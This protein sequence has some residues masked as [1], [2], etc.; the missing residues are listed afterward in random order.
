LRD[1][2]A[3]D[4]AALVAL[5][6]AAYRVEAEIVRGQRIDDAGV[7]DH[8]RRGTFLLAEEIGD[9]P[10][11]ERTAHAP[12][13]RLAGCVFVEPRGRSGYLG[14]LSVEPALQG[15]GLGEA[16]LEAAETRLFESG[17]AEVEIL[18]L[19][20]RV[21]LFPWYERRGYRRTG[22]RPFSDVG[23]LLR[24]CHFVELRKPL[25]PPRRSP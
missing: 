2:G 21:E 8:R 15:F 22:T 20:E 4:A 17:C 6:R 9:G 19:S 10:L 1:A 3:S 11:A 24:P 23:K 5:I 18:V 16:L 14:L 25:G 13:L 12:T 7:A